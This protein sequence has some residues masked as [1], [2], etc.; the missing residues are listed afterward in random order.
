MEGLG[1]DLGT[2]D[3]RFVSVRWFEGFTS[4]Y[5]SLLDETCLEGFNRICCGMLSGKL[6]VD[7]QKNVCSPSGRLR[8]LAQMPFTELTRSEDDKTLSQHDDRVCS[9]S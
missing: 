6:G 2:W 5:W 3:V 8:D 9:I 7:K 1:L 4:L